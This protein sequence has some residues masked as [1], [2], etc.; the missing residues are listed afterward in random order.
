MN[1]I[2][3]VFY[4]SKIDVMETEGGRAYLTGTLI[5]LDVPTGNNRVYRFEEGE[6]I[7]AEAVGKPVQIGGVSM[8]EHFADTKYKIGR[9]LKAWVDGARKVI[10]GVVEIWNTDKLPNIVS[11]VKRNWGLSIGGEIDGFQLLSKGKNLLM[12]CINFAITHLQILRP[13][14][15]RGDRE[16]VIDMVSNTPIYESIGF[17]PQ[18]T[19]LMVDGEPR[20]SIQGSGI[21]G[22]NIVER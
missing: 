14:E 7:A 2:I 10:R 12:K 20:F 1:S 18:I 17:F 13:N 16:A 8:G 11:E 6:K 9:I 5:R 4:D 22:V 3:T 19:F 21:S 15:P